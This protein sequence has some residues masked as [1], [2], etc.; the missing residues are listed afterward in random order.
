MQSFY[1]ENVTSTYSYFVFSPSTE[2]VISYYI[3]IR[4]NAI[5]FILQI[6]EVS[7][8]EAQFF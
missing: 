4:H 8:G 5:F 2:K 7:L 3:N 6:T 1:I